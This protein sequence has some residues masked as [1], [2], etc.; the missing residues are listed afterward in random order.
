MV[1]V[2]VKFVV[3]VFTPSDTWSCTLKLPLVLY[4]LEGFAAVEVW[5]SPKFQLN[6]TP[7][8]SGSAVPVVEK[9][10]VSGAFPLRGLALTTTTGGR[11]GGPPAGGLVPKWKR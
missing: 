2:I 6:V 4:V 11:F 5:P 7:A 1:T 9:F 10:T 8:P 3:V